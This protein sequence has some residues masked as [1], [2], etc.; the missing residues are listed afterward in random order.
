MAHS[1]TR[2]YRVVRL[3]ILLL[4]TTTV[5]TAQAQPQ[6]AKTPLKPASADDQAIRAAAQAYAAA[7]NA[8]DAKAL[9]ALWTPDGDYTDEDGNILQGREAIEQHFAAIF[10]STPGVKL[11]VRTQ[12]IRYLSPDV[13]IE[14]GIA[15]A[16]PEHGY[17]T[18]AQYSAVQVKQNGKWLLASVRDV[19]HLAETNHEYLAGLEWLVGNWQADNG[20]ERLTVRFDWIPNKNFL[21][22]TYSLEKGGK[23]LRSGT[24]I[25][26]WDPRTKEIT[27]WQFD[28]DG[29]FGQDHWY[30]QGARWY[31]T[32][33]GVLRDGGETSATN[34]ITPIDANNFSWQSTDRTA[35]G[36]ALPDTQPVK[37]TRVAPT[38]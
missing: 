12:S 16:T 3:C 25:I 6:T 23:A 22:R 13:A 11:D 9:A 19:R 28:S 35:D 31:I 27:S 18:T 1:E 8:G 5:V 36:V 34:I 20:E 38:R 2:A 7:Y 15:R 14:N 4:L 30:K 17:P 37:L 32:A 24:Q 33:E 29:G 10:A 21:V 26:G